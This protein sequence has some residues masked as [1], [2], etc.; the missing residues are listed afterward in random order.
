M[1]EKKQKNIVILGAGITG[2]TV[3][4]ELSKISG[5][6]VSLIEKETFVGGLAATIKRKVGRSEISL[7]LGSHR[8]HESPEAGVFDLIQELCGGLL[9][10]RKRDGLI[11]IRGKYLKYPPSAFDILFGFGVPAGLKMIGDFLGARFLRVFT[12]SSCANFESFVKNQIGTE[13]YER[14]Y[15]PYAVKLW[16]MSP[17]RISYDPA[18]SRMRKFSW[19]TA[20]GEFKKRILR[21]EENYYFYPA[22]GIGALSETMKNRLVA[23]GGQVFLSARIQEVKTKPEGIESVEISDQKGSKEK[24]PAD[25]LISTIPISE[26]Y[27]LVS[28]DNIQSA[29]PPFDLKYRGLRILYLFLE[30]TVHHP[31]ETF[32]FPEPDLLIGR[33]SEISKYSPSLN[34]D[35][36]HSILTIEIPCSEDDRIWNMSDSALSELCLNELKKIKI[37]RMEVSKVSDAFSV[38]EKYVY[39]VYELDWKTKFKRI[40][41]ALNAIPNLYQVGRS[42]LFLHC[43]IDHCMAMGMRLAKLIASGQCGKKAWA[44]QVKKF[45]GFKIRE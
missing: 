34:P 11:F 44:A 14:F 4:W 12:G 33:V 6:R 42:A 41:D 31:N 45:S 2:L 43:N 15:K 39:P 40:Y 18:V 38:K 5:F 3:A 32:Y 30:D 16:G 7:D 20:L 28:R 22:H 35:A 23:N 24:I 9:L 1:D 8:L 10:K 29:L 19:Q 17:E 21:G 37:L 26:L 36:G 27:R 25:I 13:L